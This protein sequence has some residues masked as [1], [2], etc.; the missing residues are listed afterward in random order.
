MYGRRGLWNGIKRKLADE[1][2][3]GDRKLGTK[4]C[5]VACHVWLGLM[6]H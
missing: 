4:K 2:P 5:D 6:R 3:A 1:T